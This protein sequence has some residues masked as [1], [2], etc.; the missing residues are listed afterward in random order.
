MSIEQPTQ[1]PHN[2]LAGYYRQP[3]VYVE[4]PSQGRFYPEGSL[5]RSEDNK[6]AVYAMTAKDELMYKTPDALASG[7]STVEVLKSCIP[8][9]L[10]PWNMPS[11]DVDA[12]LIAIRIAT[13]GEDMDVTAGCPSCEKIND[14]TISL[15]NYLSILSQFNYEA[16]I[17]IGEL[18][19]HIRPYTYKELSKTAI[20]AIEQ[21]KI[22]NVI[23]S[24]TMSEEEKLDRFGASF[25]TLTQLT[26]DII[27]NCIES[28]DTPE[29]TVTNKEMISDFINNA[30]KDVF[31]AISDRVT[32][33]KSAFDFPPQTVQCEECQHK[34]ELT[35]SMD[36]A[37]FFAV[38]S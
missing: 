38:R 21:E 4:L 7:Q 11:I 27:T 12:C 9:L 22:F 19:V 34:Y 24:E 30:P 18:T 2:P 31:Q 26:V 14:Y 32:E 36:Q 3:K 33:L 5:D 28:I 37:N 20:R 23:N 16:D 29:E 8:S 15:V 17:E 1:K 25:V 13:Y 6:Y 35:V 10:N